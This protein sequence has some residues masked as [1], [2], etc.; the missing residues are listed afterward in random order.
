MK[1]N[2]KIFII[3]MFALLLGGSLHAKVRAVM[4]RRDFEQTVAKG[5]MVVSLFYEH[6]KGNGRV[7]GQDKGLIRMYDDL[8]GYKPY[9]DA[10]IIFLKVNVGRK[11]LAELAKLY[12]VTTMPTFIFFKDGKRMVD[13]QGSVADL[14]GFISRADLQSFIDEH[15]GAQIKRYVG[16]KENRRQQVLAEENESWKLYFYPRDMVAKGYAPEERDENME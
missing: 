5:P 1:N 15:Y 9:D 7:R 4:A 6:E 14:Q 10:D 2:K 16:R 13:S 12:N 8:S 11:D 3:A